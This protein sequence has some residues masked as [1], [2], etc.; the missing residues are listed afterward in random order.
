MSRKNGISQINNIKTVEMYKRQFISLAENVFNIKNLNEVAPFMDYSYVNKELVYKGCIAFFMDEY[1]G[2]LAL[3]FVNT[4]KLDLYGRPID[5]QVIGRNG[6][7]RELKYGEYVIM[8]DN[9]SKQ[10]LIYDIL[11][12]SSRIAEIQRTIDIN[13]AQQ[14]TPR[15]WKTKTENKKTIDDLINGV[16]SNNEVITTYDNLEL[17]DT[18]IVLS[19]AP[20][21]SDKL[22]EQKDKIWN[23]F[24][25]LIGVANTSFQKKERNIRDEVFIS[26]AGTI[27]SRFTRFNSRVD[28]IDKINKKWN[29]KLEVEYYDGLPTTLKE[30]EENYEEY[31]ETESNVSDE[32]DNS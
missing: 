27:A 20:F 8:W 2:L 16:S 12:Y 11:Q 18:T 15:I 29:L 24:L 9:R 26:Q 30:E 25:R 6:Y 1:L 21:V 4:G 3:P 17:D 10:A 14:R 13:I 32:S 7:H 31:M 28:A 19:P 23:E 5:I 22:S